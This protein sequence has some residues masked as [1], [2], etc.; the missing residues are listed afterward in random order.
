[1][2]AQNTK[3]SEYR[4]VIH[5]DLDAFFCAV[6]ELNDPSL[7]GKAFSVGGGE[8]GVVVSAS[9][10]ARKFGVRSAMPG[11]R[12]KR[13]CPNIIT[14]GRNH[15][16]YSKY[17]SQVMDILRS[18]SPI[19]Q[20]IS[21]DEAFLDVTDLGGDGREYGLEIQREIRSQL[22]L[23]S[24]LGIASNKLV[25]KIATNTGKAMHDGNDY[26]N[27]VLAV[28][29]GKEIEFLAPLPSDALW[30]VGPKTSSRLRELGI[31]TIGDIAAYSATELETRFGQVG[32]Y[33][34]YRAQG[35]DKSPVRI[36]RDTKSVSHENTF[37]ENT[38][39]EEQIRATI[40]RHCES[41]AKRLNKKGLAGKTVKLKIRWPDFTTFT[42]QLSLAQA[43]ADVTQIE[44]AALELFSRH[45]SAGKHI[46]LLGVGV[47][48]LNSPK[49]Q[50]S[51]WD[52]DAA[53]VAR[54]ER[55]EDALRGIENKYG[56]KIIGT[57]GSL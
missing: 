34:H 21:I 45:W 55:L 3:I 11:I 17:S 19:T 30:G 2:S 16:E 35:L 25:A 1:M 7:K 40:H 22:G 20:P 28:A 44:E 33:L 15:G 54:K 49:S 43:T 8:R 6:E 41:I 57:A 48:Q 27:A 31:K 52:F 24:S 46:R 9:Y 50:L 39:D 36:Y 53:K 38:S 14:V 56:E 5:V 4:T 42:R 47:G 51:L 26:P 10:A 37:F 23:P 29:P 12:A 32:K 18:F 13:L